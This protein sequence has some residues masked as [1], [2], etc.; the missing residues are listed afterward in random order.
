MSSQ[1]ITEPD[2]VDSENLSILLINADENVLELIVASCRNMD[3]DFNFYLCNEVTDPTWFSRAMTKSDKI[4]KNPT[5][6]EVYAF[7]KAKNQEMF[8]DNK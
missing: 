3:R 4:F 6:E 1:L 5:V 7:L 8:S 2:I